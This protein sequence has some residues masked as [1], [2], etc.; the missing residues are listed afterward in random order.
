MKLKDDGYE[1]KG[2]A[3]LRLSN[4]REKNTEIPPSFRIQDVECCQYS[5]EARGQP[6]TLKSSA[7][8]HAY[9][10]RGRRTE[11]AVCRR[12]GVLQVATSGILIRSDPL[13][14]GLT[15][16]WLELDVFH[17]RADDPSIAH[18]GT[19][20][21]GSEIG[22]RRYSVHED[23]EPYQEVRFSTA[24]NALH[25]DIPGMVSFDAKTP[26]KIKHSEN[27]K[28]AMLPPFS[29]VSLNEMI[30]CVKVLVK[31]RNAQTKRNMSIPRPFTSSPAFL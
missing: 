23:P 8:T 9:I 27:S 11:R 17:R 16:R 26:Q 31:S 10:R 2:A 4:L 18:A 19:E 20:H 3:P 5:L 6:Q 22:E 1:L 12:I 28:L 29:A 14:T 30:K 21:G 7:K 15:S 25:C 24:L 13:L